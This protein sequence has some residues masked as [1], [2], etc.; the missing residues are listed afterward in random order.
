MNLTVDL[1][2]TPVKEPVVRVERLG[3]PHVACKLQACCLVGTLWGELGWIPI[4]LLATPTCSGGEGLPAAPPFLCP[5]R[6]TR[7]PASPS[8]PCG[9]ARRARLHDREAD[10]K[11]GE[12][13]GF[14][15]YLWEVVYETSEKCDTITIIIVR[16][17]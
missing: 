2:R 3:V 12:F 9:E 13:W 16:S 4:R 17:M 1:C 11:A 14:V 15:L 6:P 5:L 10:A 8:L 7:L